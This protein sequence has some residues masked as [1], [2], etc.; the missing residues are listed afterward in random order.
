MARPNN[1]ATVDGH[2]I[3]TKGALVA[4]AL[5]AFPLSLAEG[6]VPK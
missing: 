5:I 2:S 6:P 4:L 1:G 3:V